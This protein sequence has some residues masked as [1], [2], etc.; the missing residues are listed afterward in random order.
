MT[1]VQSF[2]AVTSVVASLAL[3][4]CDGVVGS[5]P[6]SDPVGVFEYLWHDMDALYGGFGARN[7][8]WDSIYR[9]YR[10]RVNKSIG[11]DSLFSVLIGMLGELKDRHI[12]L[13]S[14]DRFARGDTTVDD[15][16]SAYLFATGFESAFGREVFAS[17]SRKL[18]YARTPDGIGYLHLF[19]FSRDPDYPAWYD[20]LD[21]A[22]ERLEPLNGMIVDMRNNTGGDV[23]PLFE[24]AGRFVRNSVPALRLQ[25]RSGP[26]RN[27]FGAPYT[28]TIEPRGATGFSGRVVVLI[29]YN[30]FSAA[31]WF[32]L[33]ARETFDATLIGTNSRGGFSGAIDRELQNGWRVGIPGQLV[34]T[35]SGEVFEGKGLTPDVVVPVALSVL[36]SNHDPVLDSALVRLRR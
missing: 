23:R 25:T 11:D 34:S 20:E 21:A 27:D 35:I 22:I 2:L 3:V 32:S 8:D 12:Y 7:V 36:R 19:D 4:S 33:I 6:P 1:I 16:T 13:E 26:R 18:V 9:V 29:N 17:D 5:D 10:P 24:I 30:T 31:K 28:Y 14:P 15:S